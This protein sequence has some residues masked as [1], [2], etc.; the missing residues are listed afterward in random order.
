MGRFPPEARLV[1]V[2][3]R[4]GQSRRFSPPHLFKM[5][6]SFAPHAKVEFRNDENASPGDYICL[7]SSMVLSAAACGMGS[8][9]LKAAMPF[10]R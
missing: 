8:P 4:G 9:V 3:L 6:E 5:E 7:H 10:M 2:F 1:V